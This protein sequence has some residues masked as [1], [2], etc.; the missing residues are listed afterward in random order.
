MLTHVAATSLLLTILGNFITLFTYPI[1]GVTEVQLEKPKILLDV[2]VTCA[3]Y[4]C[5]LHM[6]IQVVKWCF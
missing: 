4:C 1:P 2:M 5:L 3:N 6:A